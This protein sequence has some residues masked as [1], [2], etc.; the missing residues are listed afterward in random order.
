V[1][2]YY[3]EYDINTECSIRASQIKTFAHENKVA[4]ATGTSLTKARCLHENRHGL[5]PSPATTRPYDGNY[6]PHDGNYH[7]HDGNYHPHDGNYHPH[8]ENY[9]PH[10]GNYTK[11][12]ADSRLAAFE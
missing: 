10:D 5:R 3:T 7:P 11:D 4:R 2:T 1:N 12:E 8:D 6:H 9:H